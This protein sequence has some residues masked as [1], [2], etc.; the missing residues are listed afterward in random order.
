MRALAIRKHIVTP[1]LIC[2]NFALP[3]RTCMHDIHGQNQTRGEIKFAF[4]WRV[5]ERA[6][7]SGLQVRRKRNAEGGRIISRDEN[8]AVCGPLQISTQSKWILIQP[9]Q[10][11]FF[12][13]LLP[14]F[15]PPLLLLISFRDWRRVT[16]LNLVPDPLAPI[17]L[18]PEI[19]FFFP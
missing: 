1:L 13:F 10:H 3:I 9:Q 2:V 11:F 14:I 18:T 16:I 4:Y 5:I 8:H 17:Y 15:S 7:A 19:G 12:L 6:R